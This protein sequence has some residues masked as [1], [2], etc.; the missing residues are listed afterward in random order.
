MKGDSRGNGSREEKR[1]YSETISK[2]K[3]GI[4]VRWSVTLEG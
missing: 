2:V 1:G 3:D 4:A